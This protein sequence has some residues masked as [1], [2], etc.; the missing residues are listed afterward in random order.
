MSNLTQIGD[1]NQ[2]KL[3]NNLADLITIRNYLASLYNAKLDK[4]TYK[5]IN[6]KVVLLDKQILSLS[7]I[8]EPSFKIDP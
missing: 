1:D 3:L 6:D 8:I 2:L 5:R 4:G 7:L